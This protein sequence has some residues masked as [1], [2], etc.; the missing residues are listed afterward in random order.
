[1]SCAPADQSLPSRPNASK[2][3]LT[4]KAT[5]GVA[6]T[7]AE[8]ER[9]KREATV[10]ANIT[11]EVVKRRDVSC[12]NQSASRYTKNET[13]SATESAITFCHNENLYQDIGFQPTG[14]L[15]D[16]IQREQRP[17]SETCASRQIRCPHRS[18]T[19]HCQRKA[20]DHAHIHRMHHDCIVKPD[21]STEHTLLT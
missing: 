2:V 9:S 12:R 13:A 8:A 16:L 18:V 1:M 14:P 21:T 20:L 11:M 6:F 7:V 17:A 19:W 10:G 4:S 5:H 15:C 3:Q